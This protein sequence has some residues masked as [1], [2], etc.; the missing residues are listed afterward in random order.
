M[1]R[2]TSKIAQQ[3]MQAI[4]SGCA[5]APTESGAAWPKYTAQSHP[6][7]PNSAWM[8]VRQFAR[9][10]LEPSSGGLMATLPQIRLRGTPRNATQL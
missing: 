3:T 1:G 7:P 10:L 5:R 9:K 6:I 2:A 4:R 8:S